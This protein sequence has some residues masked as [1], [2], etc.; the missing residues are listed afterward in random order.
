DGCDWDDHDVHV[1]NNYYNN[2][3]G[4]G[5]G[6]K[7]NN[8]NNNVNIDNSKTVN[9]NKSDQS[10]KTWQHNPEHRRNVGYRDP[11]TAKRY[12]G[13]GGTAGAGRTNSDLARGYDRGGAGGRPGSAAQQPGARPTN[14]PANAAQ[15]PANAA[16]QP[17]RGGGPG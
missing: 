1:N 13:Q 6:G 9:I 16:Q 17:N 15:R 7:N 2:G 3:G 11:G 10:Q 12:G 5:G 8:S 14:R 4:G